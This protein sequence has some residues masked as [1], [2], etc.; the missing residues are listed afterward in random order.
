MKRDTKFGEIEYSQRVDGKFSVY[1]YMPDPTLNEEEMAM[2]KK[3]DYTPGRWVQ[4]DV[5]QQKP[6]TR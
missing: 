4:V 1:K 3:I 6:K 2:C 5:L